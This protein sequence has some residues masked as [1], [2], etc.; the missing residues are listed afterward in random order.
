MTGSCAASDQL[1]SELLG[2]AMGAA[3]MTIDAGRCDMSANTTT[4]SRRTR[5]CAPRTSSVF[6]ALRLL[7]QPVTAP[8][9]AEETRRA[10]F[11]SA[12]VR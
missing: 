2:P 9:D 5:G 11:A 6:L 12:P 3:S 4:G 1:P 10:Y 7:N 8:D